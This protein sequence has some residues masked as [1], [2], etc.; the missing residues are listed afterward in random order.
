MNESVETIY[1]KDKE[2]ILVGTSHVSA[3]SVALVK[4]I[5]DGEHPDTICVELDASRY[6]IIQNP[7]KWA[8]TNVTEI[9]KRKKAGYLFVNL[10]LSSKV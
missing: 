7:Q 3:E 6:D 1:Y 10:V 5:I 9:I 4:K 2:I 8:N